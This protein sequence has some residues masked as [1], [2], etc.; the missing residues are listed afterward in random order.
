MSKNVFL[1]LAIAAT[2]IL[3][4]VFF[5]HDSD[6]EQTESYDISSFQERVKARAA[7]LNTALPTNRDNQ[8]LWL[9]LLKSISQK[10]NL[11]ITMKESSYLQA[12]ILVAEAPFN[13]MVNAFAELYTQGIR[14]QSI[15]LLKTDTPG[16]VKADSIRLIN[17]N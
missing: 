12:E 17:S 1:T 6:T 8:S 14:F 5:I 11:Q 7:E 2:L 3:V 13:D 9:S 16:M 15:R 4:A 10:Y